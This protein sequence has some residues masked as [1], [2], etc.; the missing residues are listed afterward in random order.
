ME[1]QVCHNT[2]R[3]CTVVGVLASDCSSE[4]FATVTWTVWLR[5]NK[6]C[7]FP[8]GFPNDQVMQR[9]IAALMEYRTATPP[10]QAV[11]VRA[12]TR[13]K[14]PPSEFSKVNFDGVIFKEEDKAGI[15]VIIRDCQGL[16]LASMSQIIPL[17]LNIVELETL[18]VAKALQLAIDLGLSKV[19]LVS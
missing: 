14:A 11:E 16:V 15:G 5:R 12:R 6:V 19:I 4:L 18:A 3:F 13:W 7:F 17:G 2:H 10:V 9:A 8:P 1:F